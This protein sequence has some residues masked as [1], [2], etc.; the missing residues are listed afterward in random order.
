MYTHFISFFCIPGE[1]ELQKATR[2][3][4]IESDKFGQ[5]VAAISPET[6][7]AIAQAGPEMQAKLLKGLGLKGYLMT[8]GNS[9][10]NLFNAAKVGVVHTSYFAP[11]FYL[12]IV[13]LPA[14]YREW[15]GLEFLAWG[16]KN[17]L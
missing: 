2:L 10:I 13:L 3:A 12:R 16:I 15:L 11:V 7:K 8:D 5:L 6:L 1:L 4:E 14:V 17:T 9:P